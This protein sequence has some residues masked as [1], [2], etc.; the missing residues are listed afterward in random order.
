MPTFEELGLKGVE[1]SAWQGLFVPKGT[2]EAVIARLNAELNK[3]LSTPAIKSQL[4]ASG[5]TVN[6]G[7]SAAM[8]ELLQQQTA[9]WQ[10]L[11]KDRKLAAD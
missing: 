7:G 3:T 10:Q 8:T 2:P 9:F 6:T 4:E 1:A 5:L 11:I